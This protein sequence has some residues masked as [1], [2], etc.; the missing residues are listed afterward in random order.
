[1][2]S[3]DRYAEILGMDP[4]WFNT[5]SHANLPV[6]TGPHCDPFWFQREWQYVDYVSREELARAIYQA[7]MMIASS[8]GFFPAPNWVEAET[9]RYPGQQ[10]G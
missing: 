9:M 7:E 10:V 8:L 1:L 2:L 6:P 3:L 5:V 4:R